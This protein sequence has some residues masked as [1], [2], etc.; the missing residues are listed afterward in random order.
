[1]SIIEGKVQKMNSQILREYLNKVEKDK[2]I[3]QNDEKYKKLKKTMQAKI[4]RK[5]D[6][7]RRVTILLAQLELLLEK[8][9][10]E[11]LQ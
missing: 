1:M 2:Q 6:T 5:L 7:D 10:D 11:N 4:Q 9:F 8:P 3:I